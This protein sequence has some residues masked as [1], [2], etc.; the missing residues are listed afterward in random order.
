VADWLR[1]AAEGSS[2]ALV[3]HLPFLD[4]LASLLITTTRTP[5][6]SSSAW[7]V[8]SSSCR[9]GGPGFA[10][11]LDTGARDRVA[12]RGCWSESFPTTRCIRNRRW[13]ELHPLTVAPTCPMSAQ[14]RL[15][16][17]SRGRQRRT[18]RRP[19]QPPPR[20]AGPPGTLCLLRRADAHVPAANTRVWAGPTT[21]ATAALPDAYLRLL[22]LTGASEAHRPARK[23]SASGPC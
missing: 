2:I 8:S 3:G 7:V 21:S 23:M 4:R 6:S 14:R 20:R 19:R 15:D 10:L 13:H 5:T 11:A 16:Q 1:D 12:V 22:T 17:R 9:V 18:I